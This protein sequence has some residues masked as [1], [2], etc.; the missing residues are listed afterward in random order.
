MTILQL[1][2]LPLLFILL[3]SSPRE[4]RL[5]H[6][7]CL[8]AKPCLTLLWPHG[9]NPTKL[10]CPRNFPGKNGLPFPSPGDLSDPGIKPKSP[11]LRADVSPSDS[12]LLSDKWWVSLIVIYNTHWYCK[13][14]F[15][16]LTFVNLFHFLLCVTKDDV[17]Y[18]IFSLKYTDK[19]NKN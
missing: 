18:A 13:V 5:L 11:A 15:I 3:P 1:P 14:S 2:K 4:L 16:I 6:C 12:P 17:N 10:F 8:V 7:C 9:L 19:H